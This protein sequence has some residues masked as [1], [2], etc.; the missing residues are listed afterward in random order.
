MH[1]SRLSLWSCTA[2][3]SAAVMPVRAQDLG[4]WLQFGRDAARSGSIQDVSG[5]SPG[6]LLASLAWTRALDSQGR[7][8][9]FVAQATP[10]VTQDL[11]LAAG[12]VLIGSSR[13]FSLYA[14]DRAS[15]QVRWSSAIDAPAL[16]SWSSP[17]ADV[18][19]ARVYVASGSTLRAFNLANGA[20]AWSAPLH[21]QVVNASPLVLTDA[22]GRSR[23]FVTDFSEADGQLYCFS[24][25]GPLQPAAGTR[26]WSVPIGATSGNTPASDGSRVFVSSL[27]DFAY[28]P[29]RIFAFNAW[30]NDTPAPSWTFD[31][32]IAEGFFSGLTVHGGSV[33]AGSYAFFGSTASANLVKLDAATGLLRWSTPSNRTSSTPVV[34]PPR[35]GGPLRVALSTGV[36]GFGS[37]PTL[38]VF[39]DAGAGVSRIFDS[40]S[41][42]WADTN[43][44]GRMDAGEFLSL[45]G[46]TGAPAL[47]I[48]P[49]AD[50]LLAQSPPTGSSTS[51]GS[52]LR[53]VNLSLLASGPS[54][55][56][57]GLST[58][59]GGAPAIATD[60]AGVNVYAVGSG[61]LI[62]FGPAAI[63]GDVNR[64]G[65]VDIEDLYAFEQGVGARD[66][67]ADGS[68]GDADRDA[69]VGYLRRREPT[70][71]RSG[72][73]R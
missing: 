44:N 66:V 60:G 61:G 3:A 68:I 32:V 72:G 36:Q 54:A 55:W 28:S 35:G 21:A 2:A 56:Q 27:G 15:G 31:N 18:R 59:A 26:L 7:A 29:G 30:A 24:A 10:I 40:A 71:M 43:Q 57:V 11:V 45:G 47:V 53:A 4:L 73:P 16:D 46:W 14:I 1:V 25:G 65:C 33:Y 37:V 8:I 39:A 38:Q 63:S 9:S 23:V 12:S 20:L 13:V 41:A 19:A 17:A 58:Q 64:D 22:Q 52:A 67:N 62:A 69:L 34:I 5:S 48:S 6:G 49:V 51:F 42:T 50:T 70:D